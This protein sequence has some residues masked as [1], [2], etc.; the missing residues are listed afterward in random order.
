MCAYTYACMHFCVAH[1]HVY[2]YAHQPHTHTRM[3]QECRTRRQMRLGCRRVWKVTASTRRQVCVCVCVCVGGWVGGCKYIYTYSEPYSFTHSLTCTC[4]RSHTNTRTPTHPHLHTQDI[5]TWA[6]AT[7]RGAHEGHTRAP[8]H[9]RPPS[10][11]SCVCV[12]VCVRARTHT[13][14]C[15]LGGSPDPRGVVDEGPHRVVL[16]VVTRGFAVL[17]ARVCSRFGLRVCGW[18]DASVC[19]CVCDC[20]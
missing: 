8:S 7:I 1:I 5:L 11:A 3:T 12:C 9:T 20:V 15:H 16:G 6:A 10:H 2:V 17:W 4:T 13:R 18:R 19:V 14:H